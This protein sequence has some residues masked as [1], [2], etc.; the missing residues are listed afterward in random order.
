MLVESIGDCLSLLLYLVESRFQLCVIF[1]CGL[2]YLAVGAF[3]LLGLN[4]LRLLGK[5]GIRLVEELLF[6]HGALSR[7]LVHIDYRFNDAFHNCTSFALFWYT[8]PVY[9]LYILFLLLSATKLYHQHSKRQYAKIINN[10]HFSNYFCTA[11]QKFNKDIKVIRKSAFKA[12]STPP[13][14]AREVPQFTF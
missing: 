7:A 8:F 4:L 5:L 1:G 9:L 10:L 14:K 13:G 11:T 12:Q 2:C 3:L 6:L